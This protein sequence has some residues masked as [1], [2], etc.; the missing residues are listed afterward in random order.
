MRVVGLAGGVGGAK[1][2][3]G[4]ARILSPDLFSVIVNTGDD[5]EYLSLHISPDVDTVCYTL[6]GMAN[7]ETGWGRKDETW[8]IH[9]E[10]KEMGAPHWFRLGDKDLATHI[11]R[12]KWLSEGTPLS[13]ITADLCK[14]WDI[15]HKVFPMT[16]D[17]V[18]TIVKTKEGS[19]LGFQE[20]F[21]HQACRPEVNGFEFRGADKAKPASGALEAI[22]ESDLVVI[23]P[24]NPWVSIDPILSVPGYKDS[25]SKKPVIAV[26][27][28]IG[29]KALKG[30]AAKMY[31][32][33]GVTPSASAVAEHYSELLAGFVFDHID[34]HQLEKIQRWR[35]IPLVTDVIMKNQQDRIRLAEEILT[36]SE[37]I[38]NRSR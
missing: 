3:D 10:M 6:A 36:F 4:L 17:P 22:N 15:E 24:S 16:D 28:I 27:P 29:G 25:I 38:L 30:P 18:R 32:E 20:Y 26:S 8:T 5:F 2:V 7:P 13:Q 12:T 19:S 14:H 11:L 31:Q 35:I 34:H 23:A 9:H 37:T 33:L 1:L 21:V